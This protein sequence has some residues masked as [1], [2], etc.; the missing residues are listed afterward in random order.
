[1]LAKVFATEKSPLCRITSLAFN[2]FS[3]HVMILIPGIGGGG[4]GGGGR[5][6][7]VSLSKGIPP[8]PSKPDHVTETKIVY[9][10]IQFKTKD[11]IL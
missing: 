3:R 8:K 5:T 10:V 2:T 11:F 7:K 6:L 1:M 9:F 4:G